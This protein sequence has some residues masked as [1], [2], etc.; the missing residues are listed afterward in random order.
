MNFPLSK[1]MDKQDIRMRVREARKAAGLRQANFVQI[2]S[3]SH[4]ARSA[5]ACEAGFLE[6]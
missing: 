2:L 5:S 4:R 1:Y 3:P 6:F